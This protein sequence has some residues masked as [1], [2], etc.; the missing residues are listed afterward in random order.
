MFQFGIKLNLSD[1]LQNACLTPPYN[2]AFLLSYFI[3]FLN[4]CT[5]GFEW[6]LWPIFKKRPFSTAVVLQPHTRWVSQKW[7]REIFLLGTRLHCIDQYLKWYCQCNSYR[8][9]KSRSIFSVV[10]FV[11]LLFHNIGTTFCD[12]NPS[13]KRENG[14]NAFTVG[15]RMAATLLRRAIYEEERLVSSIRSAQPLINCNL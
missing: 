2:C 11:W 15:M 4:L 7:K 1:R 5:E 9:I 6:P 12:M 14:T 13:P 3:I 8:G 10:A